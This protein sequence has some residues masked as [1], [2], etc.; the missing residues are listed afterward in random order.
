[1]EYVRAHVT[2]VDR[3]GHTRAGWRYP[4][5][6]HLLLAE[7][8][9]YAPGPL[10]GEVGKMP[11]RFCFQNAAEVARLHGLTYAEGMAA[12]SNGGAFGCLAH[13]WCVTADGAVIDPTWDPGVGV[14]YLGIAVTDQRLWPRQNRGLLDNYELSAPFLRGG[15]PPGSALPA[16]RSVPA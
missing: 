10:P 16:G 12:F 14:A 15:F 5:S 9:L 7:G 1:M 6:S 13:A 8:R 2:L 4:T 3:S 11:D